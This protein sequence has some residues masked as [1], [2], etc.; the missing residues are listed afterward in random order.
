M[1]H[2]HTHTHT[3]TGERAEPPPKRNFNQPLF[4]T[5][6]HPNF[7]TTPKSDH[8]GILLHHAEGIVVPHVRTEVPNIWKAESQLSRTSGAL[9][10][11]AS[12]GPGMLGSGRV[13]EVER[14]RYQDTQVLGFTPLNLENPHWCTIN[15][16]RSF[17]RPAGAYTT[18]LA[19]QTESP[20]SCRKGLKGLLPRST[21]I[22]EFAECR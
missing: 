20:R 9:I 2:P 12:S 15:C 13:L 1:L 3:S 19:P 18:S 5:P 16:T 11:E 8:Y 21:F 10:A 22:N 14:L 7:L 6:L 17:L 4:K